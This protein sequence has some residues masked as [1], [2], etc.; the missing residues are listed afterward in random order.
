MPRPKKVTSVENLEETV[1]ELVDE[2]VAEEKQTEEKPPE[3]I[4]I[5]FHIR[6]LKDEDEDEDMPIQMSMKVSEVERVE[7][8]QEVLLKTKFA[9]YFNG[10]H[11]E[12]VEDG[13][14]EL[15][16]YLDLNRAE[17]DNRIQE[18]WQTPNDPNDL[19]F[20]NFGEQKMNYNSYHAYFNQN[21]FAPIEPKIKSWMEYYLNVH[22]PIT[23]E[24]I[25]IQLKGA[26]QY[27]FIPIKS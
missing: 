25:A 12:T 15:V 2:V 5:P 3:Q 23:Q 19:I 16:G 4:L 13:S 9:V 14:S 27:S 26:L 11:V 20:F 24:E 8:N 21:G 17:L 7:E 18:L 22:N 6:A 1:L 10:E